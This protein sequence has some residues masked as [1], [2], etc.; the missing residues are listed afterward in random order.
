MSARLPCPSLSGRL[1][2]LSLL[3]ASV[4]AVI[5][6]CPNVAGPEGAYAVWRS[7]VALLAIASLL[8]CTIRAPLAH[9]LLGCRPLMFLGRISYSLYLW[10]WHFGTIQRKIQ[11]MPVNNQLGFR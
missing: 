11:V 2:R 7:P 3:L 10:H 9:V 4:A 8:V 5:L 1:S 6:I